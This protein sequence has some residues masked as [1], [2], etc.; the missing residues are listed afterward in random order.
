MEIK[1]LF[2]DTSASTNYTQTWNSKFY[3][4]QI[5]VIGLRINL[6]TKKA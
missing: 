3:K 1:Q 6:K 5:E 4:G 2:L